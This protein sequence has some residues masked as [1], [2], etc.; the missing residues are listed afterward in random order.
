MLKN[1]KGTYKRI[2]NNLRSAIASGMNI[3]V[4][5]NIDKKNI[6]N[7]KELLQ[8]L[9]KEGILNLIRIS[10]GLVNTFGS[11]CRSVEEDLLNPLEATESIRRDNLEEM[12]SKHE[13]LNR[14]GPTLLGCVAKQKLSLIVGP[15]GE[16]YKCSKTI[17]EQ[18]E[19]CGSIFNVDYENSNYKKWISEDIIYNDFCWKCSM[20]PVCSGT[21]CPYDSL[22]KNKRDC[23]QKEKHDHYL[24]LLKMLYY[25]L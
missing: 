4:R 6:H 13:G 5:I 2:L 7:V 10:F 21:G 11:V 15:E 3:T 22:I 12:I 8:D 16:I 20:V 24:E 14:P 18:K 1:G 19:I 23:D 17:G 9:E 25:Q